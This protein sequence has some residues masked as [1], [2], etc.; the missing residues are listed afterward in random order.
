VSFEY[1]PT[2]AGDR[3][4]FEARLVRSALAQVVVIVREVTLQRQAEERI[5]AQ[6]NRMASLRA[7]DLAI[8][9]SLDPHLALSLI[10]R[11]VMAQ[12]A[13]DAADILLINPQNLLE[14]GA[15]VGFRTQGLQ[16]TRVQI[17]DGFARIVSLGQKLLSVPDLRRGHTA[18]LKARQ[19][20]DEDF[21]CYYAV[22]LM[23][24]GRVRGILEVFHRRALDPEPD[25]FDFLEALAGQAA[26]AVENATLLKELQRTNLELTL[27]Y[28]TTIEG[29]SRALDLRDRDTE[30]HTQRVTYAAVKL[31][32][33][34]GLTETELLDVRRG[35]TLH[36]IGKMAIPDSILLKPGP[37]TVE[38]WDVMRQHPR[39]AYELLSPI[40]SLGGTLDIPHYHH[41]RWDGTGYLEGL[42]GRQIPL[43][44]RVFAVVDVFDAL[45]SARPYRA[46]W[47]NADASAHIV[48]QSGKHFDPEIAAEFLKMLQA[49]KTGDLTLP[50]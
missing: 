13:V 45:M 46:A 14:F 36:D 48:E 15:G 21:R 31:A 29:W 19:F 12:L 49:T 44:A 7:V 5:E 50:E 41:E 17:G 3:R 23:A 47:S 20:A 11:Q 18:F 2:Q 8:S 26:M 32:R 34:L 37:L 24:R 1:S 38:E 27:A 33:R 28:N 22:P 35:A 9:S 30:G 42:A 39:Y 40:P 25:W 10:L 6:L 4:W 43:A 16:D